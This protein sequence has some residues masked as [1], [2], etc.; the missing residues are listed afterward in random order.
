V[1]SRECTHRSRISPQ[2]SVSVHRFAHARI[3]VGANRPVDS[4]S[5]TETLR[6]VTSATVTKLKV[7]GDFGIS[8]IASISSTC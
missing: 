5:A 8:R 6:L 4:L 7:V 1:V 3:S 2:M